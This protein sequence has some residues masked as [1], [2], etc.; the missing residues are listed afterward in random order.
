MLHESVV[1]PVK[2][3]PHHEVTFP[4]LNESQD[5]LTRIFSE[6]EIEIVTQTN[7]FLTRIYWDS[8]LRKETKARK[9]FQIPVN[10]GCV[11]LFFCFFFMGGIFRFVS[12]MSNDGDFRVRSPESKLWI[13]IIHVFLIHGWNVQTNGP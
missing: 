3:S 9:Q 6:I 2:C 4:L 8:R 10:L 1:V 13:R 7:I 5:F 11:R 12:S